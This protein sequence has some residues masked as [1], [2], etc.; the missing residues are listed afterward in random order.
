MGGNFSNEADPRQGL[1][2]GEN[3]NFKIALLSVYSYSRNRWLSIKDVRW[4][5]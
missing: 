3:S 1:K 4:E 5:G 2:R